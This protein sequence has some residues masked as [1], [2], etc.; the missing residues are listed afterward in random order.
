MVT[1]ILL[2]L[3]WHLIAEIEEG[4]SVIFA[5]RISDVHVPNITMA[6]EHD[7]PGSLEWGL[8]YAAD[9]FSKV[10]R[11]CFAT[12]TKRFGL[13]AWVDRW[14]GVLQTMM[15][16]G[17]IVRD[18]I[19]ERNVTQDDITAFKKLLTMQLPSGRRAE[20]LNHTP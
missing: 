8:L 15:D 3:M 2:I 7:V 19:A 18:L 6:M 17:R 5:A 11:F 12:C 20:V 4:L 9:V 16:K 10:C 14:Y 13:Q 1:C